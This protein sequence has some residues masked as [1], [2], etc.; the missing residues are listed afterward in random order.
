M[1]AKSEKGDK[2][3]IIYKVPGQH[4]GPAGT[5]YTFRGLAD[6][7]EVPEGWHPSLGDAVESHLSPKQTGK[8]STDD[9]EAKAAKKKAAA[10][11]RKATIAAKK[12]AKEEA[13][14]KEKAD[15]EAK[16]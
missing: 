10:E 11:K 4:R 3:T 8:G 2:S 16:E 6:G 14:A 7:A 5:T 9:A 1:T 12:K 13:E 15:T